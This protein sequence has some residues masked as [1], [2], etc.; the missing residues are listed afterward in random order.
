VT[1]LPLVLVVWEDADTGEEAVDR[2]TVVSYHR[3][4]I[5]HTLGWVLKDDD[6]GVTLVNEFYS[7]SYR[8]RT[9]IPRK[10]IQSVT[11]YNLSKPRTKHLA[12]IR[13][14]ASNDSHAD[15]GPR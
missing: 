2:D 6:V 12:E 1:K 5:V 9:F 10:M 8:G 4:T 3:P 11:P 7:E 14:G 15:N 13:G